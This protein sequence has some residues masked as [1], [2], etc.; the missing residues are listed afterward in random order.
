[1]KYFCSMLMILLA[2][3]VFTLAARLCQNDRI[4]WITFF[5][6][7]VVI[8]ILGFGCTMTKAGQEEIEEEQSSDTI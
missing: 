7:S 6:G 8:T 4:G 5:I 2:G 3:W 1:M